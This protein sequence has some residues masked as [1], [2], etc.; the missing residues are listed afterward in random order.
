MYK[1]IITNGRKKPGH[2]QLNVSNSSEIA[3]PKYSGNYL[4]LKNLLE[5]SYNHF[6]HQLTTCYSVDDLEFVLNQAN[7]ELKVLKD[8]RRE[9][10]YQ[11]EKSDIY[12]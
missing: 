8:V 1:V 5:N 12:S 2:I 6:G 11:I 7:F 4:Q 3:Q 10:S 9:N